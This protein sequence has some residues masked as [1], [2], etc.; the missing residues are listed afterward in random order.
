MY[1]DLAQ[2]FVPDV[3]LMPV[4]L[5]RGDASRRFPPATMYSKLVGRYVRMYIAL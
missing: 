5:C 3:R 2:K 4:C 1:I